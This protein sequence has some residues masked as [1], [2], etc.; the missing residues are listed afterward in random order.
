MSSICRRNQIFG[1]GVKKF[2]SAAGSERCLA[3][4]AA[5]AR[6]K[7][8]AATPGNPT[9]G[10]DSHA[11]REQPAACTAATAGSRG[12]PGTAQEDHLSSAPL[13]ESSSASA[14]QAASGGGALRADTLPSSPVGPTNSFGGFCGA[15][16]DGEGGV[17]GVVRPGSVGR[18]V[19]D[20]CCLRVCPSL[21]GL[22]A[23]CSS[24]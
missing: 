5:A 23:V 22:S 20:V 12:R 14:S 6:V 2:G 15:C 16:A 1:C 17:L 11:G 21:T 7:S 18:C 19:F 3:I 10:C 13:V 4:C 24:C 9:R 8:L